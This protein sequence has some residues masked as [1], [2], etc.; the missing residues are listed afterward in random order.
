MPPKGTQGQVMGTLPGEQELSPQM[1][2]TFCQGH[3][4][5]REEET[6]LVTWEQ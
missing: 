4:E 1:S 2:L 3:M 5:Q 6:A